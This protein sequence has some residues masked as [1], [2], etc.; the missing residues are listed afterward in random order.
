[1][2]KLRVS[3]CLHAGDKKGQPQCTCVVAPSA[4]ILLATATNKLRLKKKDAA[5]ARLFVWGSGLELVGDGV[6]SLRNDDL[7]AV[8]LGE[9]YAGPL[10]AAAAAPSA[11]EAEALPPPLPPPPLTG[12]DD[13]GRTFASLGALWADA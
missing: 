2:A 3:F 9:P 13:A 6:A 7:I 11:A 8:S 10:K 4:E 1:M 5:R 12:C